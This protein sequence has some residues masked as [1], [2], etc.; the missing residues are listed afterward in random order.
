MKFLTAALMIA[1]VR[2]ADVERMV[3]STMLVC[4]RPAN[5]S[6]GL[7]QLQGRGAATMILRQAGVRLVWKT[8]NRA[9]AASANSIT[10][11]ISDNTPAAE[12]PG[13]L[14]YAR[15]YEGKQIVVFM[16]RVSSA[17][18]P[19]SVPVLLGHVLAHE[20][21]HQLQGVARHSEEGV[22]KARW[23]GSDYKDMGYKHLRFTEG[24]IM[25]IQAGMD[26]RTRLAASVGPSLPGFAKMR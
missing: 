16:D 20:I 1:G 25:L 15:V 26:K 19:R 11:A 17:V 10:I 7:T 22:M 5:G 21:V 3:D 23:G 14:A 9:C 24:D 8:T 12:L 6:E 4:Y 2:A 18:E 13:A